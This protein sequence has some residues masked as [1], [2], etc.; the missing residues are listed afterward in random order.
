MATTYDYI[1]RNRLRSVLLIFGFVA[2]VTLLGWLIGEYTDYGYDGLI[3]ALI[4]SLG[5][6]VGAYYRGDRVALWSAGARGPISQP[7]NEAYV[8]TV[9]QLCISAGLPVPRLYL[10]EDDAINAFATGRDPQHASI[11]V[12]T[13][14]L[15]RLENEEL[16]GVLAHELSHVKNFDTRYLL[17]I[18]VLVNT[19]TLLAR[20]FWYGGRRGRRDDRGGGGLLALIGIVLLILAPIVAQLV[21]FAV[22]RKRELLADASGA[23][24]TRY[25]EGLANALEKI[26]TLNVR[27][28]QVNEAVAPL[29]FA[30]PFSGAGRKLATLFST[31]PPIEERIRAL[32]AMAR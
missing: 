15:R 2:F 22:S 29:F 23:L 6:A 13:G 11:A 8:N 28:M 4:L 5:M 17:L 24:L 21:R 10:I 31:H 7:G 19:V 20:W 18:L 14:A 16:E 25:P 9:E 12:T 30:N 32:R 3:F 27:P 26:R 1:A